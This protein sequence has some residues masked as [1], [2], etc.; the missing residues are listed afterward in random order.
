[1]IKNRTIIE[2]EVKGRVYRLECGM[3][4]PLEDVAEAIGLFDGYI[5]ERINQMKAQQQQVVEP[6][7][8]VE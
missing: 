5:T 8:I 7:L 1:M 3:E 6:E 2:V 4:S